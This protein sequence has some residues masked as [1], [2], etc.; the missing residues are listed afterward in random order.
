LDF[1]SVLLDIRQ[2]MIAA[3]TSNIEALLRGPGDR[4]LHFTRPTRVVRADHPA[5]VLPVVAAIEHAARD[6]GAHVVGFLT[7]EAGRAFELS[8]HPS[9]ADLP[10]AWFA[11]FDAPPTEIDHVSYWCSH[12]RDRY[13]LGSLTP[14]VGRVE[15]ERA[16]ELIKKHIADG[17]TYQVNYTF[18]LAGT[19]VG[20]PRALFAD[21]V[22]SQEGRY[23]AFIRTGQLVI[24]S[25][26]P[27]LFFSRTGRQL[28]ARPMKGTT[29]RGRTLSEDRERR[30][31]L[32]A[33]PKERAENIMIVDMMRNDIGKVAAVGTVTVPELLT[34]ERYP[35]VWQMTSSVSA[36]TEAPLD[37]IFKALHP[38]ASVTGAPKVRTMEIVRE[39]E[40]EPRGVY[41]GAVGYVAPGGDARF[42]VAIRT[43]IVDEKQRTVSFGVGS[44]I[45]WD[46][47]ATAEYDE[48]L[49]KGC[50]LGRAAPAFDLLE[51]LRWTPDEEFY[52]L[53]RHLVRLQESAEYFDFRCDLDAVRR[54]LATALSGCGRPSRVR[55]LLDRTGRVSVQVTPLAPRPEP[56][57]AALAEGPVRQG[58]VFLY[59]KTTNR[60][61]YENALRPGADEVILWNERGEVTESTIANVVVERDD[62][63]VTPPVACGLLAG[64]FR[65][66]LLARGDIREAVVTIDALRAAR[67]FWLINSVQG[68]REAVLLEPA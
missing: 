62:A 14:T 6:R 59:H 32:H 17:D 60:A 47:N 18:R 3:D 41:T 2:T 51:T 15:F 57:Q 27:E 67:R 20:D 31:A 46:S 37:E 16:F 24:C 35:T 19:F 42:N 13:T 7:Y 28:I 66:E 5:A 34:V 61:V 10:L 29:R 68:W 30:D 44:G 63:R 39:L 1:L 36:D 48:C 4:W 49:L 50:V 8:V 12:D 38:S 58:D 23:A 64:T 33:S 52:L 22:A 56:I 53:E 54:D 11:I 45:V 9:P 25:A 55:M 43:A 40:L 65:A 26:S 21:L